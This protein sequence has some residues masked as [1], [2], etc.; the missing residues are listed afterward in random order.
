MKKEI[1]SVYYLRVFAM[2]FVVFVHTTAQYRHLFTVDSI[3]HQFYHF[4]NNFVRV[5]VG[6]FIMLVGIV[7]F[8]IYRNKSFTPQELY[9]YGKKRVVF[10]LVPYIIWSL[11]YEME[12]IY[13]GTRVFGINN[14]WENI[15]TGGSKYQLHFIYLVVQFYLL[16]PFMIMIVKRSHLLK[17]YLWLIGI[18]LEFFFFMMRMN[19]GWDNF[20]FV[21]SLGAFL[22]G[23]WIGLHYDE[24]KAK[25]TN[26]KMWTFAVLFLACSISVIYIRYQNSFI[27]QIAIPDSVYKLLV[28]GFYVGGSFFFFYMSERFSTAF[29]ETTTKRFKNVASYSFGF[30]LLHPLV[31]YQVM[32]F[33][34][35]RGTGLS[36][37]IMIPLQYAITVILCYLII[38][39]VHSYVPFANFLFGKLPQKQKPVWKIKTKEPVS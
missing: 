29:S 1:L 25:V 32:N 16:L 10:I 13:L 2:L 22:L 31:L 23:G 20:R 28:M 19:Y 11:I 38:L 8:Y 12:Q 27:E 30:Y 17:K 15:L 3:Q 33:L 34:P 35:T 9:K 26:K 21:N 37:H 6:I 24:I 14:I 5:E 4:M 7:F 36:F 18:I 39:F